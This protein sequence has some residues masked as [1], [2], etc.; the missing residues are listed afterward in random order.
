V[1]EIDET[2][3]AADAADVGYRNALFVQ[4]FNHASNVKFGLCLTM[5]TGYHW[6]I[7]V[8]AHPVVRISRLPTCLD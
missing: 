7:Q 4:G 2:D 6:I 5:E 3:V 1:R 8:T